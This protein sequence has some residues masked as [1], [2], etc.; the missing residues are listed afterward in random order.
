MG[1][2][3][4]SV[5]ILS[6]NNHKKGFLECLA[7]KNPRSWTYQ[8]RPIFSTEFILDMTTNQTNFWVYQNNGLHWWERPLEISLHTGQK[9]WCYLTMSLTLHM[10]PLHIL[11]LEVLELLM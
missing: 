11:R 2:C 3:L 10:N 1:S 8:R 5:L 7:R 4:T 9:Q 6:D